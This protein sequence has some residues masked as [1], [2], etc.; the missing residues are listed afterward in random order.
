MEGDLG[1]NKLHDRVMI[2]NVQHTGGWGKGVN[3]TTTYPDGVPRAP[4]CCCHV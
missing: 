3:E 2:H 1:C 4:D